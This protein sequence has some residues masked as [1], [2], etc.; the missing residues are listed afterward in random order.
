[1]KRLL[2]KADR[3]RDK[4]ENNQEI[5]EHYEDENEEIPQPQE[6][7]APDTDMIRVDPYLGRYVEIT[8]R[9]SKYYG[10]HAWVDDKFFGNRYK[11][12]I[13]PKRY[14]MTDKDY[15]INFVGV[16]VAPRWFTVIE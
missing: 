7:V 11:I 15:I 13:E 14:D 12:Y 6:G 1:M 9:R 3:D 2:R 10:Y 5:E 16:D 4:N 8:N